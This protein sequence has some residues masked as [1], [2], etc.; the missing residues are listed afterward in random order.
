MQLYAS[1][2]SPGLTHT[3]DT[4]TCHSRLQFATSVPI[5]NINIIP[6]ERHYPENYVQDPDVH[7]NY[8]D[9]RPPALHKWRMLLLLH[10]LLPYSPALLHYHN[11]MLFVNLS[12]AG[13]KML[14]F[15]VEELLFSVVHD[16]FDVHML[17]PPTVKL[18]SNTYAHHH[19][20]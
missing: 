9:L 1:A 13:V 10:K 2:S 19:T 16:V 8:S 14:F 6:Q 5:L 11:Q 4:Q 12:Q 3:S 7:L 15:S 17:I 18:F 20:S